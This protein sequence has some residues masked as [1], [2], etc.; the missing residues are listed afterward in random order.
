M[1]RTFSPHSLPSV[2][3]RLA[4]RA[5]LSARCCEPLRHALGFADDLRRRCLVNREGVKAVARKLG[6]DEGQAV[7]AVRLLRHGRYSPERLA[8]VVML[9]PGMD[10][11]D[12]AEIF[13]RSERW[14]RV[15]RSKAEEIRAEEPIPERLE[16]VDPGLQPQDPT[17][18]QIAERAAELRAKAPVVHHGRDEHRPG[19]RCYS[20]RLTSAAFVP[21]RV[22]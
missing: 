10:D 1:S 20:R 4:V 8:L 3:D 21:I 11:A 2:P 9:D 13:G 14:A 18:E 19:I 17:P 15:V 5:A 6:V 12:I 22:A 16:W 7:G